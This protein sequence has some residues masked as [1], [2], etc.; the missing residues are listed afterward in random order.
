MYVY[1][2]FLFCEK[3]CLIIDLG[4]T[5][6]LG[7]S[8]EDDRFEIRPA[9]NVYLN[10]HWTA[11]TEYEVG[12]E[13]KVFREVYLFKWNGKHRLSVT[14]QGTAALS[15]MDKKVLSFSLD[16][17]EFKILFLIQYLWFDQKLA[18]AMKP[19]VNSKSALMPKKFNSVDQE[20]RLSVQPAVASKKQFTVSTARA[21]LVAKHTKSSQIEGSSMNCSTLHVD[22]S[23][24]GGM[25]SELDKSSLAFEPDAWDSATPRLHN[26]PARTPW[27]STSLSQ[28]TSPAK[29]ALKTP[30]QA[31][32][33]DVIKATST[34][35]TT[36]TFAFQPSNTVFENADAELEEAVM[37]FDMRHIEPVHST[38]VD[39]PSST[40]AMSTSTLSKSTVGAS[41]P[42]SRQM[43]FDER[44]AE[45]QERLFSRWLNFMLDPASQAD[46][47][48]AAAP[49]LSLSE[50]MQDAAC[51]RDAQRVYRAADSAQ[52]VAR[53]EQEVELGRIS[54][55]TDISEK[56]FH[57]D[58]GM[59]N[60]TIKLYFMSLNPA[61]LR[62]AMETV[63]NQPM[64]YADA[65]AF[66]LTTDNAT[67][68]SMLQKWLLARVWSNSDL[69]HEYSTN[70]GLA[71][72]F[73]DGYWAA[74]GKYSLK[75]CLQIWWC[76][77]LLKREHIL[78]SDPR[79]FACDAPFKATSDMLQDF[80]KRHLRGEA[81]LARH[82]SHLG[83]SMTHKQSPLEE[84]S[85]GVK[86]LAVE[87]R[88]GV[89]L[90]KV[91]ELLS[92]APSGQLMK[93]L[94]LP[95][96][97]RL[98]KV[99]NV[100]VALNALKAEGISLAACSVDDVIDGHRERTLE[101]LWR[102]MLHWQSKQADAEEN[103]VTGVCGD[104]TI[105]M[106]AREV[107]TLQRN[108][109]VH[110]RHLCHR[111]H[112]VP[113]FPNGQT[114]QA[115]AEHAPSV[116]VKGPSLSAT[117]GAC[118]SG[119]LDTARIQWL[120]RWVA[121]VCSRFENQ[122]TAPV[123]NWSKSFADGRVLCQLF[124][125]YAPHILSL[126]EIGNQTSLQLLP[127]EGDA[128]LGG[129]L[130]SNI[131]V[132]ERAMA[133]AM[134]VDKSNIR[135][136]LQRAYR[137]G[138]LPP[139]LHES[140]LY[141]AVPD[142]RVIITFVSFLARR[143]ISL[144]REQQAVCCIQ[145][146]WRR[147]CQ[148]RDL[149]K[150]ATEQVQAYAV[151]SLNRAALKRNRAALMDM[152]RR[153][154]L[155]A[156]VQRAVAN[157]AEAKRNAEAL[158]ARRNFAALSLQS[159]W[160]GRVA[161]QQTVELRQQLSA[162]HHFA[163]VCQ[164]RA[165]YMRAQQLVVRMQA[166]VRGWLLRR[167]LAYWNFS[168][169]RIQAMFRGFLAR[170]Q[171]SSMKA[172]LMQTQ[173]CSA[174]VLHRQHFGTARQAV[175][176]VQARACTVSQS[177]VFA[178]ARRSA[179]IVQSS[180]RRWIA[181]RQ[182]INLRFARFVQHI[183][184]AQSLVRR[185]VAIRQLR[186]L[187]HAEQARQ[188]AAR[189]QRGALMLQSHWRRVCAQRELSALRVARQRNEAAVRLQ[190]NY[191]RLKAQQQL[192]QLRIQHQR[193]CA[194]LALQSHFRRLKAQQE[195]KQLRIAKQR[196]CAA[197]ALQKHFRRLQA[198]K[199]LRVLR[200]AFQRLQASIKM[201]S[202]WRRLQAQRQLSALRVQR[203]RQNAAIAL[204]S[205]WRRLQAQ[206][207]LR[208]MKAD[209]AAYLAEQLRLQRLRAAIVL[210]SHFR[211]LCAQKELIRLRAEHRARVEK[212]AVEVI[213]RWRAMC[214]VC[215]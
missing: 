192:L 47:N 155:N 200:L 78:P 106:L 65:A 96:D 54:L 181:Q 168:A 127:K 197:V 3:Q 2:P 180:V 135:M 119:A 89:R 134:E 52:V 125:F 9:C 92:N 35:H 173:A 51:R 25:G 100:G 42:E 50:R 139:L 171:T 120:G 190:A 112:L 62:L 14:V 77:E 64:P 151:A 93:Q 4:F 37:T 91:A 72:S 138:S 55:R 146:H 34:K 108:A 58:I 24:F 194:A 20:N 95:S 136:F 10:V 56:H 116:T 105:A 154:S 189:R 203:R 41:K 69:E 107:R 104:A 141:N 185:F 46:S 123:A 87:L 114:L 83:A 29:K 36:K 209:Y 118:G 73:R 53:L 166:R 150:M 131:K 165:Q 195:L 63:L 76:V 102:V 66:N 204:Q 182:L 117:F 176:Q 30:R 126:D 163:C 191:R 210:Q 128:E 17:T 133:R 59:R 28:P 153:L 162:L 130:Q 61:W 152:Q 71:N 103:A 80:A 156:K 149:V 206:K 75:R 84:L 143:L 132:D 32:T 164:Q 101:L 211:S 183:V 19:V 121:S 167:G 23:F 159:V 11:P 174:V 198:Q 188:E 175:C 145:A 21:P 199:E 13:G 137:L 169:N 90:T 158:A 39:Q 15:Q 129:Y 88:D 33:D 178:T 184:L 99:H 213:S 82:L 98:R 48:A 207:S 74:L 122:E 124:H 147:H 202:H 187:K 160:R 7:F 43:F 179:I 31:A 85:L 186:S 27:I 109:A 201:Q 196:Q 12:M 115:S 57:A 214:L 60:E 81:N 111:F 26:A 49:I 5:A 79:L 212:A 1:S 44:W 86:N 148:R 215:L 177:S 8:L 140:D 38:M 113:L 6:V 18:K 144:N 22:E 45:K 67:M 94:R 110:E 193:Q 161:R 16:H 170:K 157:Y 70:L 97:S 205:N 208:L 172:A 142:E 68:R 40:K